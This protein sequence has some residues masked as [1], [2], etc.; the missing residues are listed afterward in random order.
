MFGILREAGFDGW[1]CMEEASFKGAAGVKAAADF[2]KRL[3]DE[4]E[5]R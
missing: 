2:V 4:T 5:Q 1:I 3:W